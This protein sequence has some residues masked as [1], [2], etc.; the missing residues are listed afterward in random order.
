[1]HGRIALILVDEAGGVAEQV[2]NDHRTLLRL[3]RE[4]GFSARRIARFNTDHHVLKLG[5]ILVDRGGEIELSILDQYHGGHAGDRLGHRGNPEDRIRLQRGGLCM[6]AKAD[7]PQIRDF[8]VPRDRSHRARESAR[9][10]LS[11]L[12]GSDP[13]Q[14]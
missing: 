8:A 9:I 7:R 2:L 12:P 4:S 13:L 11:L 1:V 14:P 6:V 10:D 5:K 3:K